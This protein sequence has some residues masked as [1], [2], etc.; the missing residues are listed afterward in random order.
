VNQV[1]LETH[2]RDGRMDTI[3]A[4]LEYN[5]LTDIRVT[6]QRTID[7]GLDSVVIVAKRPRAR[8]SHAVV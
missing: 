6:A 3:R 2:N 4:L 8:P 7:N 1:V 5:G